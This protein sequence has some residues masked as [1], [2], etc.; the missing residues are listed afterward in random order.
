MSN[1]SRQPRS[2]SRAPSIQVQL[3][4]SPIRLDTSSTGGAPALPVPYESNA[5]GE[6]LQSVGQTMASAGA[7]VLQHD[8]Q[9]QMLFQQQVQR[10]QQMIAQQQQEAL[11]VQPTPRPFRVPPPLFV[12]ACAQRSPPRAYRRVSDAQTPPRAAPWARTNAHVQR[13][14]PCR[15]GYS[16]SPVRP[17]TSQPVASHSSTADG[18]FNHLRLGR[19]QRPNRPNPRTRTA[20]A[21][22][23]AGKGGANAKATSR[24][25]ESCR[26]AEARV[27]R[28]R[29][30][31]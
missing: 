17:S 21:R 3:E 20:R 1:R 4:G 23:A 29:H 16:V 26:A 27:E 12:Q 28:R 11:A 25:A 7:A 31:K 30:P 13:R 19:Q 14:S 2:P 22:A 5:I 9:N 10:Q 18:G 15:R 6:M 24:A 8:R